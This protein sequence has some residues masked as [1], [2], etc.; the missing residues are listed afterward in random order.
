MA[1]HPNFR[2]AVLKYNIIE[3]KECQFGG[4]CDLQRLDLVITENI[5]GKL[6]FSCSSHLCRHL[7]EFE[8]NITLFCS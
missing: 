5:Q 3:E 1:K 4:S 6:S 8:E 2:T 7:S